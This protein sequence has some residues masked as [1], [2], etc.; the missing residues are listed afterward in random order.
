MA[1][2]HVILFAVLLV[3]VAVPAGFSS[4]SAIGKNEWTGR[5]V[6]A[7]MTAYGMVFCCIAG[8]YGALYDDSFVQEFA[9][10]AAGLVLFT[11]LITSV[12]T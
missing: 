4:L 10:T 6:V 5:N 8:L 9:V 11:G 1:T 7:A 2:T 3:G 12:F